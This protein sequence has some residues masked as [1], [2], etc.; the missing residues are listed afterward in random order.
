[1]FNWHVIAMVGFFCSFSLAIISFRLFPLGKPTNKILHILWHCLGLFSLIIGLVAV[2]KSHNTKVAGLKPNLYSLHSWLGLAAVL[3]FGQNY[4]MGLLH[5][6]TQH[7]PLELKKRYMPYHTYVGEVAYFVAF[8]A[9]ETGI[10]EK[11]TFAP[12]CKYEIDEKD[13]NPAEHY[14]DIPPGCRLSNGIGI[15]I[16]S[17]MICVSFVLQNR[18]LSTDKKFDDQESQRPLI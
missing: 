8:A 13:Y 5:Y 15:L 3:L 2:F 9:V 17:L 6:T 18:F 10:M 1:M 4:V 7:M 14:M 12:S 11:N 16:L